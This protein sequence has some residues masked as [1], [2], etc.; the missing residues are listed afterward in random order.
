[1][2]YSIYPSDLM[3]GSD[4]K[5]SVNNEMFTL[6]MSLSKMYVKTGSTLFKQQ[7]DEMKS[8]IAGLPE[9]KCTDWGINKK[10][11]EIE[12]TPLPTETLYGLLHRVTPDKKGAANEAFS[13]EYT[14]RVFRDLEQAKRTETAAIVQHKN[15]VSKHT[16]DENAVF[17]PTLY[18]IHFTPIESEQ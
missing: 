1:M 6:M 10:Q 15:T 9:E 13:P 7:L 8:F 2:D 18:K 14:V 17:H 4:S 11:F 12:P 3:P 16:P 5:N